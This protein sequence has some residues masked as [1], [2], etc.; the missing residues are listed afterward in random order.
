M[1]KIFLVLLS[2]VAIL[3]TSC[4]RE[5]TIPQGQLPAKSQQFLNQYFAGIEISYILEDYNSYDVKLS[6]GYEVDFYKNGNW[7][8]VDCKYNAIP[9][10]FAPQTIYDYVTTNFPT[11]FITKISHDNHGYEVELNNNLELEFDKNGNFK[12]IDD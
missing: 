2:A 12:R 3:A 10:G 11:N 8:E 7:K 1:K 4:D 6:N 5:V 9:V